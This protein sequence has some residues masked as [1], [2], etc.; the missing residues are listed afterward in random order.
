MNLS[1]SLGDFELAILVSLVAL[2]EPYGAAIR[3]EVS[4]RLERDVSVGA[5]YV[6][7]QRLEA[8]GLLTSGMTD[9]LPVRGGRSRRTYRLTRDGEQALQAARASR[10]RLW[11]GVPVKPKPA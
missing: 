3:R 1:P 9:P 10:E 6:T 8:K 4:E 11:Q 2:D 7:L 5:V